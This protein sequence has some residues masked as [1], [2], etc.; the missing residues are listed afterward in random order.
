VF[1]IIGHPDNNLTH[2]PLVT[3]SEF[4]PTGLFYIIDFIWFM[5]SWGGL[6][7]LL[8]IL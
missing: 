3:P 2:N 1:D 4:I 5:G 8:Y 6:F 7:L